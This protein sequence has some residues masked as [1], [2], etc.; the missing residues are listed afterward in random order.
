[1]IKKGIICGVCAVVF[2]LC[3]TPTIPAQQYRLVND[4]IEK[5]FQQHLDQ[6]ITALRNMGTEETQLE[7]QKKIVM[8][9]FNEIKQTVD[10]G[11]YDALPTCFK[12]LINT[13]LSLIFAALGTLF[14]IVF[15]PLLAFLVKVITAPAVLLAK[16]I[17]LLFNGTCTTA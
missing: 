1:M 15:G 11:C 12:F 4:T 13:L 9:S 6:A 17:A 2:V 14:G 5:D 3:I 16:I 8:E 10:L 7:D